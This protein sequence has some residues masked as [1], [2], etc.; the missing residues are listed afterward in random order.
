MND[1]QTGMGCGKHIS[2]CSRKPGLQLFQSGNVLR[3]VVSGGS[4]V[5]KYEIKNRTVP[6]YLPCRSETFRPER[7]NLTAVENS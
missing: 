3:I 7:D 6:T 2:M 4:L 1:A 5:M